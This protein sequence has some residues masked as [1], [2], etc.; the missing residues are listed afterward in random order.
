MSG[1][2]TDRT[3]PAYAPWNKGTSAYDRG[4]ARGYSAGLAERPWDRLRRLVP[5]AVAVGVLLVLWEGAF[6]RR[7]SGLLRDLLRGPAMGVLFLT[8]WAV[9]VLSP[10]WLLLALV[11]LWKGHAQRRRLLQRPT[12]SSQEPF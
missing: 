7:G 6:G 5:V 9:L 4:W 11:V 10:L 8:A 12:E 1:P 3:I 2:L